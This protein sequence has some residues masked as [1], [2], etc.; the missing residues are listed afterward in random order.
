MNN[1]KRDGQV[2][3]IG[4]LL[5]FALLF[6][7]AINNEWNLTAQALWAFTFI[8]G[9]LSVA[10]F[11]KPETFGNAVSKYFEN[12]FNRKEKSAESH[13]KQVQ[14]DGS[15][16]VQVIGDNASINYIN[17][18]GK[19]DN[20]KEST[21]GN[22]EKKVENNPE[23]S[24]DNAETSR[25]QLHELTDADVTRLGLNNE[26]LSKYYEEGSKQ[27]KL[28]FS[29]A[30]LAQMNIYT[31]PL[32]SCLPKYRIHMYFY[33]KNADKRSMFTVDEENK[34]VMHYPP[35][36][37]VSMDSERMTFS[38]IPWKNSPHWIEFVKNAFEQVRPLYV[39]NFV[40]Y[41]VDMKPDSW[42]VYFDN[43][44]DGGKTTFQWNGKGLDKKSI[45]KVIE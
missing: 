41:E 17:V 12:L 30:S 11:W 15:S 39:F 33:S 7:I 38:N 23:K 10:C 20:K 26:V 44:V 43:S 2:A 19:N 9:G 27:A 5:G 24:N 40:G 4:C 8:F 1:K 31:Y 22:P 35:I 6:V 45:K 29:D 14:R 16:G 21:Q 18:Q 34:K 42:V 36:K 25:Y 13:T 3:G 37:R 32:T 28:Q